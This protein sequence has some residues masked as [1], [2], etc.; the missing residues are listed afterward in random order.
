MHGTTLKFTV[1]TFPVLRLD[2][3]SYQSQNLNAPNQNEMLRRKQ[4]GAF[5]I[6]CNITYKTS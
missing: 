6:L 1:H 5:H 3:S 2:C 4:Y